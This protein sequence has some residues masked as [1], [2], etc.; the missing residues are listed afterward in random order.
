MPPSS[1]T[2][3][4][5]LEASSLLMSMGS[6]SILVDN[7]SSYDDI[8]SSTSS[9]VIGNMSCYQISTSS[10]TFND[11]ADL[12]YN[13]TTSSSSS[14][15]SSSYIVTT[16]PATQNSK[17]RKDPPA[18]SEA[19]CHNTDTTSNVCDAR[20]TK[21]PN[22]LINS[23]VSINELEEIASLLISIIEKR[24]SNDNN[25]INY[26]K[27]LTSKVGEKSQPT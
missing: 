24:S 12:E 18:L 9:D 13:I 26:F 2:Q 5:I 23:I 27:S 10:T 11:I 22:N 4:D 17:K 14:S 7:I 16:L 8:E 20:L 15:S 19:S 3:T 6:I 21:P 1:T 25:D